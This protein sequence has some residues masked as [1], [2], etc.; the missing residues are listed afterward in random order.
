[1]KERKIRSALISVYHKE[2]L[3]PVARFLADHDVQI[4]STGGTAD[5]LR[6]LGIEVTEIVSLTG[7]P[8]VLGGRVKTL[9][10]KV[11][12]GILARRS[13]ES[14]QLE[15]TK[16]DIPS[17]DL[18]I[19]DLYPFEETLRNTSLE[20]EIIEKINQLDESEVPVTNESALLLL[21]FTFLLITIRP[22]SIISIRMPGT[23]MFSK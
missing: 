17:I 19:V 3:E 10:P 2:G 8:A 15:T 12:G 18:V 20:E 11:F 1:M 13:N 4:Y 9:H 21:P 14:D 16:Y 23:R 7:F 6:D 5:F 22:Y